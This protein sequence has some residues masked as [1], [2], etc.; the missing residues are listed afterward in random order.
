MLLGADVVN[1]EHP[2]RIIFKCF[3]NVIKRNIINTQRLIARINNQSETV[4]IQINRMN[5]YIYNCSSLIE[6]IKWHFTY[7]IK[8]SQNLCFG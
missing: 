2:L 8:E 4:I 7:I 1:N 3:F 5:K 6:I